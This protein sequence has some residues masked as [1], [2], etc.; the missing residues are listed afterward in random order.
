MT[1]RSRKHLNAVKHGAF[2][3]TAVLPGEDLAE[4]EELHSDLIQEWTPVGP[5]EED[6]VLSIAK[7]VWRKRRAQKLLQ[8]RI[9]QCRFDPKHPLYDEGEKVLRFFNIL[10]TAPFTALVDTSPEVFD[11]FYDAAVPKFLTAFQAKYLEEKC[12]RE[13]FKSGSAWLQAVRNEILFSLLPSYEMPGEWPDVLLGRAAEFLTPDVFKQELAVDERVDAMIDRAVKRLVQTKA[14]KQMLDHPSPN[15][16]DPN[17]KDRQQRKA[18]PSGKPN[19][20][21]KLPTTKAFSG[22]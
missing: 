6:A 18:R 8:A 12:P 15:G 17:G 22:G 5:T 19:G 3:K 14:I 13:N 11:G 4:F 7:G 20:P 21:T 1:N 9:L 16:K 10:E 2:A